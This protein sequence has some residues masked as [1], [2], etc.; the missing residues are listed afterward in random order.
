VAVIA[1]NAKTD[2]KCTS[3]HVRQT[4]PQ[5]TLEV[6]ATVKKRHC[7]HFPRQKSAA[8]SCNSQKTPLL[9]FSSPEVS[10]TKLQ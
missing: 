9:A 10:S 6:S 5:P 3:A 2:Q 1:K 4:N 8:Q 7:C